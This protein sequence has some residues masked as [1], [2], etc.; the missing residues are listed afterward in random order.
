MPPRHVVAGL[1]ALPLLSGCIRQPLSTLDPAGPAAADIAQVWW[2][3][4]F[5]SILVWLL[6]VV[7]A[8]YAGMHRRRTGKAP[9]NWLLIGGGL[10]LPISTTLALLIYGINAGQSMLPLPTKEPV[11]R[12]EVRGHQWWW[13]VIY[14]DAPGG[15]R[16]SA[17]EI[18][19]PAGRFVD[20][21][22]S[23][24][25]VI[26]SFWAPA[27]AARSTPFRDAPTSCACAPMRPALTTG[28]ARNSVAR[29]T[30]AC[31]WSSTL[32]TRPAWTSGCVPW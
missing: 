31:A 4:F 10:V 32:M 22:V 9:R 24:N 25:D 7:L 17:N 14:L 30:P 16:Y 5:G 2:V 20:V 13:E 3:M 26:H 8:L 19:I 11:Y 27:W 1:T 15:P 12:V 29:S 6:V 18:H 23:T 28:S 21:H